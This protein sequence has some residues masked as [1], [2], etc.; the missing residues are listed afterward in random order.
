MLARQIPWDQRAASRL[1]GPADR[2]GFSPNQITAISLA[3]A[4]TAGCLF[5]MGGWL[6][7]W[8]AGLFLLARFLDHLDGELARKTGSGSRFGHVFDAVTGSVSYAGLFI[9]IGIGLWRDGHGA[10][11]IAA[12]FAVAAPI[13]VN[14]LVQFRS[15]KLTGVAPEPY[16]Q[17]GP[18]E[19]EDA[20]YLMGP[21]VWFGGVYWFF[22]AGCV[23]T[24]IACA[25]GVRALVAVDRP[26]RPG[27]GR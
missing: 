18:F 19:L 5:A 14:M 13:F 1:V 4:L 9:G 7:H 12:G 10:W 24:V 21:I 20:I 6:V 8:A 22:L 27:A 25:V 15:E 23:G 26:A 16:P 17:W 11:T 2:F 3:G